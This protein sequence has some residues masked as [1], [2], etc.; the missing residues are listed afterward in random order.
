MRT[1]ATNFTHSCTSVVLL[2]LQSPPVTAGT[3]RVSIKRQARPF[4]VAN[5]LVNPVITL[6]SGCVHEL[7]HQ[8]VRVAT[9]RMRLPYPVRNH[10]RN[11]KTIT[12]V[13]KA[14]A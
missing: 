8:G 9:K 11:H 10:V 1:I 14:H 6:S 5:L 12:V 4:M 2:Y 13:F 3:Q 7:A